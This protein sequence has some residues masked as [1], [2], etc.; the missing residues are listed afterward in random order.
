[1]VK[2]HP[3]E[4]QTCAE[5]KWGLMAGSFD[6]SGLPARFKVPLPTPHNSPDARSRWIPP[7]KQTSV[8]HRPVLNPTACLQEVSDVIPKLGDG[9]QQATILDSPCECGVYQVCPMRLSQ[10][11]D[12]AWQM[13]KLELH[14][15]EA[16][17]I[18]CG[19]N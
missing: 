17:S 4:A 13:S 9:K 5:A 18:L 19:R 14:A 11:I 8:M 12:T 1:M 7:L 10:I 2:V 15:V 6:L 3:G 16:L